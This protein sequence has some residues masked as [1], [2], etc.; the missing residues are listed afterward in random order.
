MMR[1]KNIH[2]LPD[3]LQAVVQPGVKKLELAQYLEPH[4]ML[5]GPDPASNP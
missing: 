5:F 1:M 4:G 2:L 3:D